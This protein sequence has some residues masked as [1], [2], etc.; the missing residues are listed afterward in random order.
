MPWRS[1]LMASTRSS[2]SVVSV[3]CWVSTS[4]SS[5]SARRLTAPSRSRS[6]RSFSRSASTWSTGGRSVPGCDLGKRRHA[7]RLDFEHVVDFALDVLQ[8]ALG[9]F[10]PLFGAG[11]GF[12]RRRQRFERGAGGAIGFRHLVFG[13][14]QLVGGLAAA[15]FRGL[16][17]GDQRAA[18]LGEHGRR[19]FELGALGRG[20]A[21]AGLD[22]RDLRCGAVLAR[23][24]FAALGGDRLQAAVG[25][26]GLARQRLRL[27]A[28]LCG[29]SCDGRRSL[30]AR[31]QAASRSPRSAAV[32][33]ATRRQL[34]A[35]RAL[36]RGRRSGACAPRPAPSCARHGG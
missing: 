36:R 10:H 20:L 2:R 9:A 5:S 16:D 1:R 26:F 32:R 30:R 6:R 34:H 21:D 31:S 25:E 15:G 12:A 28:D 29:A 3:V 4:R 19:G 17:L 33:P 27:G 23:L 7:R 14:G 18:L 35:R 13:F 11:G 8:P 24:P 22:G